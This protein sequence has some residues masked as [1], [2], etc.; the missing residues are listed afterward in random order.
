VRGE[1]GGALVS[2]AREL[3][4]VPA[5]SSK[6]PA[7]EGGVAT[8]VVPVQTCMVTTGGCRGAHMRE[9]E[10]ETRPECV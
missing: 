10:T 8:V 4:G 3:A 6:S 1:I 5:P 7:R 2:V 9:R